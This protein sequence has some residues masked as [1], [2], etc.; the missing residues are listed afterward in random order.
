MGGAAAGDIGSLAAQLDDPLM[1]EIIASMRVQM[2]DLKRQVESEGND[3]AALQVVRSRWTFKGSTN[4]DVSTSASDIDGSGGR[5]DS[6]WNTARADAT[7]PGTI[8]PA[9]LG[10]CASRLRCW[11]AASGAGSRGRGNAC[12]D[13]R[14]SC[15][16]KPGGSCGDRTQ[17]GLGRRQLWFLLWRLET[18]LCQTLL[19]VFQMLRL[20]RQ[21]IRAGYHHAAVRTVVAAVWQNQDRYYS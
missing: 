1:K 11:S 19:R 3:T 18:A 7:R 13:G 5:D 12:G 14:D 17:G 2:G 16:L 8:R 6:R 4:T 15:R 10:G 9:G 20:A 21:H